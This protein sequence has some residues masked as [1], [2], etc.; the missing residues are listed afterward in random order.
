M[1]TDLVPQVSDFLKEEDIKMKL[2]EVSDSEFWLES[3]DESI[4][5]K[6]GIDNIAKEILYDVFS[7]E[8][9]V[10]LKAETMSDLE[11]IDFIAEEHKRW[12]F[13]ETVGNLWLVIEE[14]RVW[15]RKNK[16]KIKEKRM[17]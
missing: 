6:F 13:A 5:A 14:V 12:K 4:A 15:A 10:H 7:P 17:I 2:W 3:Q 16:F 8:Y 1:K 11:K 9:D